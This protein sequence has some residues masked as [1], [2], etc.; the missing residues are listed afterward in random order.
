MNGQDRQAIEGVFSRLGELER[1]GVTRDPQ[2]DTFIQSRMQE[3]PGAAYFLAQ[4]VVVQDQAL[5]AAQARITELE[6]RAATSAAGAAPGRQAAVGAAGGSSLDYSFGRQPSPEAGAQAGAP[7]QP[8]SLAQKLGF[9]GG[10]QAGGAAQAAAPGNRNAAGGGGGFLAG[11]MQTAVGVAGGMM[12]GNMLGGLF[13]GNEANAA[14]PPED[15]PAGDA[16]APAQDAQ[17]DAGYDDGGGI[18]DG[19]GF[20]G[21][22]D[23]F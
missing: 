20:D 18:D 1:Q 21:G 10:S 14:T 11:A 12:L 2:A 9:G 17:A 4:T 3:Q 19:G 22:F 5:Q 13:G 15:A 6:Q 16:A 7:A 23:D 8:Q